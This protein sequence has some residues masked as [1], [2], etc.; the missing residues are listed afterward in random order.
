MMK[1]VIPAAF[2]SSNMALFKN[3]IEIVNSLLSICIHAS[4]SSTL[5]S[6]LDNLNDKREDVHMES[7]FTLA[8]FAPAEYSIAFEANK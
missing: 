7:I 4:H 2:Y 8:R 1:L 3:V 6:A 5:S